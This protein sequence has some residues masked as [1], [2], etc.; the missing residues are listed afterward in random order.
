MNGLT[1]CKRCQS[2]IWSGEYCV[3]CN[4]ILRLGYEVSVMAGRCANGAESDRGRIWHARAL[5]GD[6][7]GEEAA[8]CGKKPGGKSV[9]WSLYPGNYPTCPKCLEV[10]RESGAIFTKRPGS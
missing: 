4:E 9:G 2:D 5:R 8:L 10:L 1:K 6:G 7:Y 3:H